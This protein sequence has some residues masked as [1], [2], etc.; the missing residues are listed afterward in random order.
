MLRHPTAKRLGGALRALM[1][2]SALTGVLGTG[3]LSQAAMASTQVFEGYDPGDPVGSAARKVW[4]DFIASC[5]APQDKRFKTIVLGFERTRKS[6]SGHQID[7]LT[8]QI[9]KGLRAQPRLDLLDLGDAVGLQALLIETGNKAGA[10]KI[11]Q[12]L[13]SAE[14]YIRVEGFRLGTEMRLDIKVTS[15]SPAAPCDPKNLDP[16]PVP[17]DFVGQQIKPLQNIVDPLVKEVFLSSKPGKQTILL[18]SRLFREAD[19]KPIVDPNLSDVLRTSVAAAISKMRKD[20]DVTL[21]RTPS[22]M[23]IF[24]IV[25]AAPDSPEN[26]QDWNANVVL[27]ELGQVYEVRLDFTNTAA[28]PIAEIGHIDQNEI[29]PINFDQYRAS[30]PKPNKAPAATAPVDNKHMSVAMLSADGTASIVLGQPL[31]KLKDVLTP[32]ENS[33]SYSFTLNNPA[34]VEFDVTGEGGQ[35]PRYGVYDANN[36]GVNLGLVAPS[37]PG[38]TRTRLEAGDYTLRV[39]NSSG[40]IKRQQPFVIAYRRAYDM[41]EALLPGNLVGTYGDWYVGTQV[42]ASDGVRVCYAATPAMEVK[43]DG[44]RL[45]KPTLFIAVSADRTDQSVDVV[46]DRAAD[47]AGAPP[48][49]TILSNQG[50][51][52]IPVITDGPILSSGEP[53]VKN[54][55]E[56]CT[57]ELSIY[58]MNRGS[59]VALTGTTASGAQAEVRYSLRGYTGAI[60]A[61]TVNCKQPTIAETM[62]W[63]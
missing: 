4:A 9:V 26:P 63:R 6:F 43:P 2:A 22:E 8:R 32:K 38:L 29:P 17:M 42:R 14:V 16:F 36:Q 7:Y 54:P 46:L 48:E 1:L 56:M 35:A 18:N 52:S 20:A 12:D 50:E 33:R 27:R 34:I 10:A 30:A 47:Y 39:T 19:P 44:W 31:R 25:P 49:A 61:I 58:N 23:P 60:N 40:S 5:V 57:S 28:N 45:Q 3:L 53:C 11:D 51:I 13:Q 24:N 37:R 41:L 59:S 62:I 55:N 21:R 15:V